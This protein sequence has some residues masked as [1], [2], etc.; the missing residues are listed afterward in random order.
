VIIVG[1]R[2]FSAGEPWLA[3]QGVQ[4]AD[5]AV[6]VEAW[7]SLVRLGNPDLRPKVHEALA[8]GTE[9]VRKAVVKGLRDKVLPTDK[10]ALIKALDDTCTIVVRDAAKALVELGDTS[11]APILREKAATATDEDVR[12]DLEKCALELGG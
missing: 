9:E 10:A 4:D 6:A 3:E 2:G 11:V 5:P 1:K 12:G 8:S 7:K